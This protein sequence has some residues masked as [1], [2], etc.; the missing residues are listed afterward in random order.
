MEISVVILVLTTLL[1]VI[2]SLFIFNIRADSLR[3][4]ITTSTLID[5]V[6]SSSKI[7]EFNIRHIAEQ[8]A[9]ENKIT[10][11]ND[12]INKF[13][14]NF[15]KQFLANQKI[16]SPYEYGIYE[17]FNDMM[18]DSKNYEVK[19]KD[20]SL[21]FNMKNFNFSEKLVDNDARIV[22]INYV[23]NITFQVLLK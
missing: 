22:S 6:Y 14:S 5:T 19:I 23:K 15:Y 2:F 13:K 10:N 3:R 1:L 21:S 8:V 18:T 9:N 12:F 17:K 11:E 20:N 7:F 4:E 16:Y